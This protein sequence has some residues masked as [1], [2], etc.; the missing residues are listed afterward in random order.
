MLLKYVFSID[1]HIDQVLFTAK[2]AGN[3]MAPNTA[4]CFLLIGVI[5]IFLN[6][7]TTWIRISVQ[8]ILLLIL[9]LTSQA[10]FGYVYNIS[11]LYQVNIYIPMALHVAICF[12]LLILGILAMRND[13]EVTVFVMKTFTTS[14]VKQ[15]VS[16]SL[17]LG[18]MVLLVVGVVTY[19]NT[20]KLSTARI[21][22]AAQVREQN[23]RAQLYDDLLNAETGQRGYILTGQESYLAPYTMGINDYKK[24]YGAL[25]AIAN[26]PGDHQQLYTINSLVQ[27]KL[28]ELAF[29]IYLRRTKGFA[30]ADEIVNDN[31]G[32]N[33]MDKLRSIFS[34]MNEADAKA[35]AASSKVAATATSRS[36]ITTIIG[37]VLG[38]TVVLI[39]VLLID[40][41]L[42]RMKDA[43]EVLANNEAKLRDILS[44][45]T[46]GLVVTDKSG[47]F[48]YFN[49]VAEEMLGI[50][51]SQKSPKEWQKIYGVYLPDKVTPYPLDQFPLTRALK[52]EKIHDVEQYINNEKLHGG[53][54]IIVSSTPLRDA[55]G[56]IQGAIAL[57][58]DAT[59]E[60][61]ID[62]MKSEFISLASH[63]LRTPLSA[64]KWFLEM[65]LNGDA[66]KLNKEQR[67]MTQNVD[68][69]NE[70]MISL[71]NSLLNV[72]RIE[73]GRIIITPQPTNLKDLVQG[74][75]TEVKNQID[76]KKQT[77]TMN[78]YENLPEIS[79]DP[80]LVRQVYM[81]LLTN[82]IKYTPNGGEITIIISKGKDSIVSQITDT[83]YGIPAKDHEKVFKKFYRGE[84]IIKLETDGNGLG[85]YLVK[86]IVESSNGKIWF[87]SV[88]G[89]GTTFWFSLPLS[90]MI[91][92]A[93]E[94]RLDS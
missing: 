41:D 24:T 67:E 25:L 85:M 91:A 8:I 28:S 44:N 39:A 49:K 35:Y 76:A 59:K 16:A 11:G 3:R 38:I 14:S 79:I 6:T 82:A 29:T 72:T 36:I 10:I 56:N 5:F 81:N 62:R 64:M 93:G 60:K 45:M 84:N 1:L 50:G 48:S 69:S 71:V 78:V 34:Q 15:K 54:T 13:F 68:E 73:S 27:L 86:A 30:A 22:L 23:M 80:L 12:V 92:K 20:T 47:N 94:V 90:G 4:A 74:V 17:V 89:K 83:G 51:M 65:L 7:K 87:E 46:E 52:G 42:K 43:E 77:L 31:I 58:R 70:R 19:A 63:Q 33:Y 9:L 61:D 57:F 21:S 53:I 66:G 37:T 75:I 2:L 55:R 18:L 26:D 32:K 40:S 88:E